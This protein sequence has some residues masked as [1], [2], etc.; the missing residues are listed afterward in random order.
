[1]QSSIASNHIHIN[2]EKRIFAML[3]ILVCPSE[4]LR[5]VKHKYADFGRVYYM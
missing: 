2:D 5:G 4:E 3:L 1:M